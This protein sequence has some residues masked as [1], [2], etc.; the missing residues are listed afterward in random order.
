[1]LRCFDERAHDDLVVTLL[2]EDEDEL[3]E[4]CELE[5][6]CEPELG[7]ELWV[8][9]ESEELDVSPLSS[10]EEVVVVVDVAALAALD[11][12][13]ADSAGSRP[14]ISTSAMKIQTATNSDTAPAITRRRIV[15]TRAARASREAS[16]RALTASWSVI[17]VPFSG[18][19]RE[20]D[21]PPYQPRERSL[22]ATY[23]RPRSD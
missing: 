2:G 15:R 1:V 16:A 9:P 14:V 8:A 19:M 3:E 11:V 20:T 10:E 22:R 23:E 5:E 17:V 6:L 21:P 12:V 18:T 13:V 4:P 7:D